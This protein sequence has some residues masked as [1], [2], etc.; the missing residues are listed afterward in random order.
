MK[1]STILILGALAAFVVLVY[2]RGFAGQ[3]SQPTHLVNVL[4]GSQVTLG[5]GNVYDTGNGVIF[6]PMTGNYTDIA[7]GRIIYKGAGT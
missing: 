1:N 5:N 2:R 7:T 6:D 3:G 4:S